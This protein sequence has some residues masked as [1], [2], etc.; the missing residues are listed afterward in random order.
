MDIKKMMVSKPVIGRMANYEEIFWIN[1]QSGK[2][3]D[4]PFSMDDI[5]DAEARLLRFAPYIASAFPETAK[6]GGIIESKLIPIPK[7]KESLEKSLGEFGGKLFL[8]CDS[9]LPISGS[10]KARGGIYEVLKLA[11]SI[12]VKSGL[13]SLEDDYSKLT[14]DE[15][16]K[17][18][19]Q[20]SVAVG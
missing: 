20:Y 13:L 11:E 1:P 6:T 12:A 14:G 5:D 7:M 19:S 8:K 15:F 9:H 17:L 16:K 18:F 2:E 3:A 10:I 4:L